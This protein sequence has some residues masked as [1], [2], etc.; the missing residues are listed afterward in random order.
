MKSE[1]VTRTFD[2]N[3]PFAV[4]FRLLDGSVYDTILCRTQREARETARIQIT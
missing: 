3:F 2:L 4:V 1:I